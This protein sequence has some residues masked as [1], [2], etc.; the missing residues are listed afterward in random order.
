MQWQD[1]GVLQVGGDLDLV[2]EALGTKHG[3]KLGLENLHRDLAVVLH[4]VGEVDRCHTTG[5]EL[6]LDGVAVGEG[7]CETARLLGHRP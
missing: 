3:S 7:D 5:P 1:V 2:Q 4:V 6:A